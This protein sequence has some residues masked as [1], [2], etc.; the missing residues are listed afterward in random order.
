VGISFP[1][2]EVTGTHHEVGRQIGEAAA[3]LVARGL[4]YYESSYPVLAGMTFAAA[5]DRARPYLAPAQAWAPQL[6]DQVRGLAEGAGVPF[7][8]L[9]AVNCTEEFTCTM[10]STSDPAGTS[11][12]GEHCTSFAFVHGGRTYAGHNEDWYPGDIENLVLRQVTLTGGMRYIALC[13]AAALPMT[14]MNARG[15]VCTA[16]TLYSHD[17][18]VGVPNAF[19]LASLHESHTLEEARAH[20][21]EAPRAR[22]SSHLLCDES[23]RIWGLETTAGRSAFIDGGRRLAHTNHYLSPELA[24]DDA[25]DAEG[26]HK[27]LARATELL[28][29]GLASANPG[30]AQGAAQAVALARSV[31]TDHANAPLSICAHW[32]DDDPDLDQSVTTA[33]MVWDL[34]ERAVHVALGQPCKHEYL[35]YSL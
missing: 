28:D 27:R 13:P 18:V 21:E 10:E 3:D 26:T 30:G 22:A 15:I 17:E 29:E 12:R 8:Y 1:C 19:I 9:F 32:D 23:G 14:A 25:S 34:S 4:A 6:V 31:L 7:E 20:I 11:P 24:P 33:S 16:T 5:V 2:I 35:T